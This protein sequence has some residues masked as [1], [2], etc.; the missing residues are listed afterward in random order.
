MFRGIRFAACCLS[1][2]AAL[3]VPVPL[4]QAQ[5]AQIPLAPIPAPILAAR[6]VFI[7]NGG[8][9]LIVW[10]A[11]QRA[12]IPNEPHSSFYAAMKSWGRYELVHDPAEADLV[13][14]VRFCSPLTGYHR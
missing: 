10:R 7:S 14:E 11:F 8:A 1:L 6:K 4:S 5:T 9:D 13:F 3:A 12:G 2:F